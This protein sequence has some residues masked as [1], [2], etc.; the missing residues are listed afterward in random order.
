LNDAELP[1]LVSTTWSAAQ[2]AAKGAPIKAIRIRA[3]GNNPQGIAIIG[4]GGDA[5]Q[6]VFN[7]H[8]GAPVPAVI[9]QNNNGF[10]WG[11]ETHQIGKGIHRGSIFGTWARFIDF[12]AGLALLYLS[13]NGLA[14]YIDFRKEHWK[15]GKQVA[16]AE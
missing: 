15:S 4:N 3:Q 5:K 1:A 11:M 8:T 2:Q 7:A 16:A 12:F 13:I 6:V 9:P 14:L 10:P